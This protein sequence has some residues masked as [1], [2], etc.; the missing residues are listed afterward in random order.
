MEIHWGMGQ[1]ARAPESS[2]VARTF[3][4]TGEAVLGGNPQHLMWTGLVQGEA[5]P[6]LLLPPRTLELEGKSSLSP[7]FYKE[8]EILGCSQSPYRAQIPI[9]QFINSFIH[10]TSID[11][12][13]TTSAGLCSL[14]RDSR[15]NGLDKVTEPMGSTS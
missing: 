15:K 2:W 9:F 5:Q 14:C 13:S 3:P 1:G 12:V 6:T 7:S 4:G 8:I 10:S 11:E